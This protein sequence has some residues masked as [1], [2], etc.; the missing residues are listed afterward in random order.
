MTDKRY[1]RYFTY[2]QP[3]FK[4]PAVRTY[5]G[6]I[7]TLITLTIFIIFAIKPTGET[8]LVLQKKLEESKS[9]LQKLN[10]K[11]ENLLAAKKNYKQLDAT[12]K[13]RVGNYIPANVELKS[14]ITSLE[15]VANKNNASISA[16]QIQPLTLEQ[17]SQNTRLKLSEIT[18]TFNLEGVYENLLN[19]LKDLQNSP[20]LISISNI[21][22]NKPSESSLLLMSVSG[23]AYYLQ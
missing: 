3:V 15:L 21:I 9:A 13:S 17:T 10:Q 22:F 16:I 6:P 2:I 11:S 5:G 19:V 12:T 4:A 23:K 7:L 8:I 14:L 20:R 18:F 1:S